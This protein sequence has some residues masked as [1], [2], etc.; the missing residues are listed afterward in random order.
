MSGI[1]PRQAIQKIEAYKKAITDE[2]ERRCTQY[3]SELCLQ[4]IQSRRNNPD[5]HN[6]TGNLLNSIVVG[7]Y[8]EGIPRYAY[9]ASQYVQSAIQVKMS[10]GRY[11]FDPDY[12]GTKSSY[13]PVVK[14][15]GGWGE[16]DAK[17]FFESYRPKGKNLFDIVVAY[18]VEYADF[19]EKL[20]GTT[21]IMETW[22]EAKQI[23]R[24]YLCIGIN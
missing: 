8:R 5:A 2:I 24:E 23:G 16:E 1:S 6:F 12:D 20:R 13:V 9:Y 11:H 14:T 19:I 3:C 10:R 17:N 15:N 18:P 7:L 4:A 21:G 22:A